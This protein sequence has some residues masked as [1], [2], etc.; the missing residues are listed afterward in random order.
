MAQTGRRCPLVGAPPS[1]WTVKAGGERSRTLHAWHQEFRAQVSL[2]FRV[3]EL[4]RFS[5]TGAPCKPHAAT[6]YD[7]RPRISG[8]GC[9]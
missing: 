2:L 4:A 3:Q 8:V 6:R 9:R 7:S 5:K 1:A